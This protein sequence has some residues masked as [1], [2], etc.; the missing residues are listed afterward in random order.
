MA[1]Y[2]QP[3]IHCGELID[4]DARLCNRCGSRSPFADSCPSCLRVV[5]K[6]DNLCAGCGR[7]LYIPC[8]HCRGTT[9]VQD[10]CQRCGKSL[11]VQC[12]NKR[13]LQPQFFQN[14]KCTACGKKIKAV[15]AK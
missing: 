5:Q 8:P 2:K 3:C 9:F 15:L 12:E 4:A 10:T 6:S 14:I 11:M 13:C 7:P 1:F